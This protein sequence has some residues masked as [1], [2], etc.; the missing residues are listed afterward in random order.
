MT[1]VQ[2]IGKGGVIEGIGKGGVIKGIGK[3]GIIEGIG[4]GGVIEGI[5]KGGV[6]VGIGKGG[7]ECIGNVELETKARNLLEMYWKGRHQTVL[8]TLNWK[9]RDV[10]YS[11]RRIGNGGM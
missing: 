5:R 8:E 10:T 3:G 1:P 9:W 7:I 4:K 2:C 11:K 6:I